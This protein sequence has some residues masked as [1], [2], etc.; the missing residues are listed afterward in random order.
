[1]TRIVTA[2]PLTRENFAPFGEV[3]GMEALV[4]WQHPRDGL[5]MPGQFI[6]MAEEAGLVTDLGEVVMEAALRD[7]HRW[8][9]EGK[10]WEVAVNVSTKSFSDLHYPDLLAEQ[11]RRRGAPLENII[12]SDEM[13]QRSGSASRARRIGLANASPTIEM[14]LTRSRCTVSSSSTGSNERPSIVTIGPP[15]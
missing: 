8:S 10:H 15:R 9:A 1:M 2:L 3:I 5:V 13:S 14:L 7:L 11:A 4:R 12:R 6:P